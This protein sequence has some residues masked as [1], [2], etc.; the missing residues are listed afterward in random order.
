MSVRIYNELAFKYL[1][2]YPVV[3]AYGINKTNPQTPSV[4][5][6]VIDLINLI[7]LSIINYNIILYHINNNLAYDIKYVIYIFQFL[8]CLPVHRQP[9]H[10]IF[11]QASFLH[12]LLYDL[13][14]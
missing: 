2:Y 12:Y 10:G 9:F 1:N 13:P 14:E 6:N 11:I 8:S 4:W 5:I 3:A 7:M